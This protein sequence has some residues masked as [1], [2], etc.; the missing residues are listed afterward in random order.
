MA[1]NNQGHLKEA[2][3]AFREAI[4]LKPD[5]PMAY[6]NLGGVLYGQGRH[7]EAEAEFREAI[8][9]KPDFPE[10]HTNFGRALLDQGRSKEA[11]AE[12]REALRLKP[13]DPGAHNNLGLALDGQGRLK[14]AEAEYREAIRLKPDYPEAHNNVGIALNGQGHLKEAEAAFREAIRLKPDFPMAYSNL[15]G[16]LYG[17]GRYKEAEEAFREAI[18]LKPDWAEVHC[19]LGVV[20]SSE[21]RFAEALEAMRRGHLLGSQVPGWRY[22]SADWV[23]QYERLVVLDGKLPAVL[24]GDAEPASATERLELASLCQ[25]YNKRLH[26]S[27][28][29]FFSDAFIADPKLAADLAQEYRY[30]AACSASLAAAGQGEDA[31]N[32]PDKV[33]QMLRRLALG[34]LRADL[35][36][37]AKLVERREP[38]AMQTARERLRHWQEDTDFVSVRDKRVL[39]RLPDDER[40]KWCQFWADVDTLLKSLAERR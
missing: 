30:K 24:R 17:Q 28:V 21:G 38:A 12:Y 18:R 27:A 20:L 34:W 22:P 39:D 26:V 13:D 8:R 4:R 11:E 31:K 6:S 33:Q 16:V 1:L 40:E 2:E 32:L 36:L 29:R 35:A 15:G 14:E 37:L 25:Q 23:R 9:L 7:K 10:A 5:F 3:A 19:N